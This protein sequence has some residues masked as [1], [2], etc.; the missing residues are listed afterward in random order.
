MLSSCIGFS[1]LAHFVHCNILPLCDDSEACDCGVICA[2]SCAEE[3][4]AIFLVKGMVVLNLTLF[5]QFV[6]ISG[7]FGVGM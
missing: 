6:D 2:G 5:I 3:H 7:Q 1:T 4:A